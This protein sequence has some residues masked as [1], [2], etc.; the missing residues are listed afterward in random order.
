MKHT[1]FPLFVSVLNVRVL[2]LVYVVPGKSVALQV[3]SAESEY[4]RRDIFVSEIVAATVSL[5]TGHA[6]TLSVIVILGF[7]TSI[8]RTFDDIWYV[9]FALRSAAL[10]HKYFPLFVSVF[11]VKLVHEV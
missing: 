11:I 7:V 5:A 2:P 4:S 6:T 8:L 1:H 10:K 3:A 9:V